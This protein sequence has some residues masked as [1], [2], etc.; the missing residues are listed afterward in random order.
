MWIRVLTICFEQK[1]E[2]YQ[3]LLP[4]NFHFFSVVKF[5]VYLNRRVF[6]MMAIRLRNFTNCIHRN[7]SD[8]WTPC[9]TSPKI[10]NKPI[11]PHFDVSKSWTGD[12]KSA[13]HRLFGLIGVLM[14]NG[15]SSVL[16]FARYHLITRMSPN[17]SGYGRFFLVFLLLVLTDASLRAWHGVQRS[18]SDAAFCGVAVQIYMVNKL[19]T[20]KSDFPY[21]VGIHHENMPK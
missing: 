19:N 4:E 15:R 17:I 12:C 8:F 18:L 14:S 9:H 3:N 1:Y 21:I 11:L 5:S 7:Y 13:V 2:K 10:V 20:A 6:I 16:R